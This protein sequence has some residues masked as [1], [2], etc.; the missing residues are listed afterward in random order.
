MELTEAI[1]ERRSIRCFRP[2]PVPRAILREILEVA[3][4][5]PSA[6]NTQPWECW[7]VEGEALDRLKSAMYA[8]AE[9]G[10]PPRSDY[11]LPETWPEIFMNRMRENGKRLF[12]LLGIARE[13]RQKRRSFQLSMYH[14][15]NAPQVIFVCMDG[16]LG[17]Y[18]LFDCGGYVQTICLLAAAKGLGTCIMHSGVNYPD[19]IRAHVP[20]PPEKKIIV[21]IAIG[22]PDPQAPVNQFRSSREPLETV[23]RWW[24]GK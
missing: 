20:I 18:G 13:D 24:D 1:Q 9:R 21:G 10:A 4:R 15:F 19:I 22:D 17:G 6:I 7:V 5:A 12:G 2:T 14:Y 8:E 3:Q 16:R 23:V 11:E